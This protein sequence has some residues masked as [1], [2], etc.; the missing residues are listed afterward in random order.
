MANKIELGKKY[1]TRDGR[2]VRILATDLKSPYPVAFVVTE[3]DG[4]ERTH[5]GY[6]NGKVLRYTDS[7]LDLI[8]V[9][10]LRTGWVNVYGDAFG[11]RKEADRRARVTSARGVHKRIAC[12]QVTVHEGDGLE[13]SP[14][15]GC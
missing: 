10:L 7:E 12:I 15:A 11:S 4:E 6:E 1:K 8:E 5:I 13:D 14:D 9:K 2:E 3:R